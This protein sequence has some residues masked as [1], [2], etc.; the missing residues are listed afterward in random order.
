LI[1]YEITKNHLLSKRESLHL[2]IVLGVPRGGVLT[3]LAAAQKLSIRCAI[4]GTK[5][6]V[7]PHNREITIGAIMDSG[8]VYL[9]SEL[10]EALQIPPEYVETEKRKQTEQFKSKS[11][12]YHLQSADIKNKFVVL[13][14]DGAASGATLTVALRHIK[15]LNPKYTIVGLPVAPKQ[16]VRLLENEADKVKC[17]FQP[18]NDEFNCVENFYEDYSPVTDNQVADAIRTINDSL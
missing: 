7:A 4:I 3:A 5:R 13:I 11:S 14:D 18:R 17:I 12:A 15:T 2:A 8:E 16:T 10:I 9:N 1:K 6:L